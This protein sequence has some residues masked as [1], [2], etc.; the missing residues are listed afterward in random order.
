MPI[1]NSNLGAWRFGET[2][3]PVDRFG[4]LK[5]IIWHSELVNIYGSSIGEGTKVAAFVEIGNAVIGARC[6]IEAFAFIPP[7]T[8]IEDNV[9]IGPHVTITNDKYPNLL[10]PGWKP[11]PVMIRR[12]ARVGAN[13]TILPGV[14]VGKGALIGAGAIVTHDVP[15]KCFVYGHAG[16]TINVHK[17]RKER[18][19]P[20]S[21]LL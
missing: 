11:K 8:I 13:A 16:T 1:V 6:K 19:K 4:K 17:G 2:G 3:Q 7:G 15:D 14:T 21:P 5:V 18:I 9:F 10:Q 12:G 20:R